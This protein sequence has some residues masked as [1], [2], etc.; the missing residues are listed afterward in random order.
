MSNKGLVSLIGAGVLVVILLI[1]SIIAVEIT[2]VEGNAVGVKETWGGGVEENVYPP[3][4][5]TLMPGFTQT[6]YKYDLT[7]HIFVMNNNK[8]DERANGRPNDAYITKSSDNQTMIFEL[9]LQWHYDPAKIVDIHKRYRTHTGVN[10]WEAIIEERV[11]RQNLMAAVN[12]AAT[13]RTAINAY[14]GQGFV[15]MQ[16]EIAGK[17]MDP[18]GELREQGIVVENFV[19]EK[20]TLDEAYISEINLRQVAQQRTL[21]NQEEEKAAMAAAERAK[22]EARADYEKRVVEAERDKQVQVLASEAAAQQ[23]VNAA[24]AEAEKV[25]LA[26]NAEREAAEARAAAILAIGSA[27]AESKKLQLSAYAVPGADAFVQIEV[28]KSMS[29]AFSGIQGYLPSDMQV[30][31]LSESFLKSVQSLINPSK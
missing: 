6:I 28:A 3:K 11:I 12:T 14:S 5:Y 2:T 13:A 19:I 20:I 24:K 8:S 18:A 16:A 21:R 26:A 7:P 9:A 29:S 1:G 15:A 10:D 17:L 30:N 23:Q 27:E 4:T 31:L 25:V 22:A